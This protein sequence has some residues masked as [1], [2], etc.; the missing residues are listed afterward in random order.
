MCDSTIASANL[1]RPVAQTKRV[2]ARVIR[3]FRK[4]ASQMVKSAFHAPRGARAR[5]L[6]VYHRSRHVAFARFNGNENAVNAVAAAAAA[7]YATEK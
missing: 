2:R 7:R 1:D 6:A 5:S 3:S 4:R